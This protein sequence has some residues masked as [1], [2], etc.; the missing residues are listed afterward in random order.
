MKTKL[1]FIL[2][3]CV[4]FTSC[5]KYY[6]KKGDA[7]YKTMQ[8]SKAISNYTKGI[9]GTTSDSTITKLANSY[10]LNNDYANAEKWYAE[11]LSISE[12]PAI[13]M[14]YYAKA[15]M[16]NGKYI[17][18]KKWFKKYQA[19]ASSDKV[20]KLIAS[21]DSAESFFSNAKKYSINVLEMSG[22]SSAFSPVYYKDGIVFAAD[23]KESNSEQKESGWTGRSYLD[24]YGSV[25]L[26]DGSWSAPQPLSGDVNGR[27]HEGPAVFNNDASVLYFTRSN[28]KGS[29]KLRKD[30]KDES[31]L[32]I[33][34]AEIKDGVWTNLKELPFNSDMYSCGHPALS[35]D[36]KTMY[37]IS[38]MPG[39]K[40][41]TDL[42][43]STLKITDN[44]VEEWSAPENLGEEIN[45]SG[46]EMFPYVHKSGLFYFSSDG[47]NTMGGL[48]IYSAGYDGKK[49]SA[50]ENLKYP[51]NSSKDDFGFILNE[52]GKSGY[53]SSDR[54]GNDEIYELKLNDLIFIVKGKVTVRGTGEPLSD[55]VVEIT[56]NKD[57]YIQTLSVDDNG[58]YWMKMKAGVDYE[59]Q[60]K[61]E[62]YLKPGVLSIK[63]SDK[64]KSEVFRADFQLEKI[65]TE[66]PIVLENIYYDL[67]QWMI[68]K[69]AAAELDKFA[70]ILQENPQ[71]SIVLNAHTD[72]RA[73]D[74]YNKILSEKR[75]KAA[76]EYLIKKGVDS[77]RLQWKGYG[78]TVLLN[79]C[80]NAHQ[81][82]EQ[83][84]Q[85]NRR[86][87]FQIIRI[88]Q[89]AQ[90]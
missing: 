27:Y 33:F 62:G 36:G 56:N 55:A 66:K 1:T 37:F 85:K 48:D 43:K 70:A 88:E 7:Y 75:A 41:G 12:Q 28:Y 42:Y 51:I 78:E 23:K 8:Y 59:I 87:E 65:Q 35:P 47:H 54:N 25:K 29:K 57:N 31:N 68:R 49:W 34:S 67:D 63:T 73:A 50:P 14:F 71:I 20:S 90:K 18:A 13:N 24:L 83:E 52:D 74:D 4:T 44:G 69:D 84:H 45:T 39:S 76:V 40:G 79:D 30:N 38:D 5:S 89:M 16:S 86:T 32:K 17:D 81:C 53:I 15:L 72:S 9:A 61:M 19:V 22:V 6:I 82:P 10:R 46:N 77:K 58:N 64:K 26:Q 80:G 3:A 21:C 60:A 2:L 11:A